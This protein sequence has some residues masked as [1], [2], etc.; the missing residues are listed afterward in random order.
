MIPHALD[1]TL[2]IF[3]GVACVML[4]RPLVATGFAALG[5]FLLMR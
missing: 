1:G 3:A 5:I 4:S 2:L